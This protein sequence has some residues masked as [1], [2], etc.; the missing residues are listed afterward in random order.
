MDNIPTQNYAH[1]NTQTARTQTHLDN[2]MSNSKTINK[3]LENHQASKHANNQANNQAGNQTGNQTGNQKDDL[4]KNAS[5]DD[6]CELC[7][8]NNIALTRHHLIPQS[9][10]NK[11]R[12]K[13]H[14]SKVDMHTSIAMLCRPCHNQVHKLFS[15]HELAN[16]YHSVDR[17]KQHS[18]V[19]KFINWIKKRPAGLKVKVR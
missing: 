5:Q 13:R 12:T 17:L 7:G 4:L 18:D 2:A 10:H 19:E 8:R 3:Q 1:R 9:R 14:F 6:C 16:Y 15:N 11:A